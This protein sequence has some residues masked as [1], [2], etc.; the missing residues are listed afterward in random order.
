MK[1]SLN[2]IFVGHC[3]FTGNSTMHLFSI[4]NLLEKWGHSCVVCVP[5]RPE[6][7]LDHGK[8]L[9]RVLD[10]DTIVRRGVSFSNGDGP[11]LVHAWTP[12]ELVRE[13]TLA[14]A[15]RYDA[16]FFV[17]LEDNETVILADKLP[18]WCPQ[19]LEALPTGLLDAIVPSDRSHPQ[20]AKQMLEEAAGVSVLVDRLLELKPA[21]TPAVV[22]YPGYDPEFLQINGRN[23]ELRTSLAIDPDDLV[24]VYPGNI[25]S[26]NWRE[27]SSL[28][29]A[30]AI[31]NWRGRP[32]KLIK[33]GWNHQPLGDLF[34]PAIMRHVTDLGFVPRR[35]IPQLL[36]AADVLVQ[37][38]QPGAFNDFRVPAK[39]PEFLASGR[40]VI[41]PRTNIG[42]VVKDGEEALVLD[43]GDAIEIAAALEWLAAAPELRAR[44][45]CG[46]R[47]FAVDRLNWEKS[48]AALVDLYC[49]CLNA[50]KKPMPVGNAAVARP[51]R[52]QV[53]VITPSLNHGRFIERTILSV[54]YQDW[55]D[56]EYLVVDGGSTDSTREILQEYTDRITWTSERD[57]GQS[58][59]INKG[60]QRAK[61]EIIGWLNSDDLYYPGAISRVVNFF[62]ANSDVDVVYGD[63]DFIDIDGNVSREFPTKPWD[64]SHFQTDCFVCQPATFFR[65]SA[66]ERCG[67]LDTKLVYCMDY[68]YW[69]RLAGA[70]LRFARINGKLAASRMYPENKTLRARPSRST[71][72]NDMLVERLGFVPDTWLY[73]YADAFVSLHAGS[74]KGRIRF[75]LEREGRAMLAGFR[76]NGY[77]SADML[78]KIFRLIRKRSLQRLRALRTGLG[79]SGSSRT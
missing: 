44:L 51:A 14:L 24:I 9:F 27:V 40:P 1:Q 26:S 22:F 15:S 69:L 13:T 54:L 53:T 16:P 50:G 37:P 45:G 76:W 43:R 65:R 42:R 58:D 38:G 7:V 41:L 19:T 36:A 71:E 61:G 32:T 72:I 18:G 63:A 62:A 77:V 55:P 46:G 12:R 8:P 2:I 3:D 4:A 79:A 11:D 70:G 35:T 48:A 56:I 74:P 66:V 5:T 28:F 23:D 57:Y 49:G 29:L 17:H 60:L 67:L 34:A 78:G 75:F 33:T 10:H 73:D 47:A 59:A 39:L 30:V 25:H 31:L 64:F 52:T 6:T 20:R 21:K 68:E